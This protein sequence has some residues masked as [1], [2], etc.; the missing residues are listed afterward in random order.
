MTVGDFVH[1]PGWKTFR[2]RKFS[3]WNDNLYILDVM[4]VCTGTVAPRSLTLEE[5]QNTCIGSLPVG[6]TIVNEDGIVDKL[7]QK[8]S[9]LHMSL[10]D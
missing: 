4:D 9:V 1:S 10:C 6:K 5:C 3:R 8:L 2:Y 7:G